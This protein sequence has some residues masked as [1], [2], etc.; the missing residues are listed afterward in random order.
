[1]KF[2]L[3]PLFFLWN[4]RRISVGLIILLI[5]AFFFYPRPKPPVPVQALSPKPFIQSISVSGTVV[6]RNVVNLTFPVSGKL[7]WVGVKKGDS[8]I[9]GQAIASEDVRTV[10]KNLQNTLKAYSIQRNTFDST[11]DQYNDVSPAGAPT[12]AIQRILQ[13]NQY[14]L[15]QAVIS[16]ELQDL[17]KQQATLSTPIAGVVTRAD[18]EVAGPDALAGQTTFTVTDPLSMV[19][20]ADVDQADVGKISQNLP[21]KITFDA[22]PDAT[23]S[24]SI[25]TIDLVSH[26]TTNG[27]NAFTVET[28]L[29][30]N[31]SYKYRVGMN[32]NADIILSEKD[33]VVSVPLSSIVNDHY[34]YVKTPKGFKK[35][36]IQIGMRND[37]DAEVLRGVSTG[38]QI[39]LD[40]TLAQQQLAK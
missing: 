12:T 23:L 21:M 24:E 33:N 31:V 28:K 13:N 9:Q 20:D 2:L 19:F 37:T 17:A 22:Y 32:A 4:H 10:Q 29:P 11:Q 39:A 18:T 34:V 38:D 36:D 40:P 16:V 7:V 26:T 14:N 3:K 27:G 35:Q 8:V 25:T 15:D 6:A 30:D 1:M 5:L